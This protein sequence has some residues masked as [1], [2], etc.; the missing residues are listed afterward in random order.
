MEETA[1]HNLIDFRFNYGDVKNAPQ[2]AEVTQMRIGSFVCPSEVRAEPRVGATLTH[3]PINYA[4]NYGTWFIHDAQ[5]RTTGD[6]AFVVNTTI[7]PNAFRDGM[8]KTL[9]FAEVKAYQPKISNSGTPSDLN[10]APPAT[11]SA[12]VAYG[13]KFGETGHTEWVDGK[14]HETGFTTTFS[15]NTNVA[16]QGPEGTFDVDFISKSENPNG[17]TPTYAA[18][19]ARSYHTDIVEAALMD[20]SVRTVANDVDTAIWRA[21]DTRKGGEAIKLP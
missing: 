8:S 4:I 14:V 9:A 18:V 2:H 15:P 19:T 7:K 3:F 10:A 6:G 17:T 5:S 1:L 21:M 12:A 20:G 11:T 13:G 16:F